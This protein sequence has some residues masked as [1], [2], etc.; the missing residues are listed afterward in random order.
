MELQIT[1]C[2]HPKGGAGV[3]MSKFNNSK[4]KKKILSNVHKI[5]GAH[6]S[7]VHNHYANFEF[8]GMK[9]VGVTDYTN[10][11]PLSILDGKISKFNTTQK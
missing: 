11:T 8:K 3:I 10:Q 5:R 2:K 7:S 6:L 1:Q 4:K 9:T